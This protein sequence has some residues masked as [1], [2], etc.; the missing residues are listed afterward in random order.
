ME[1]ITM[2]TEVKITINGKNFPNFG[3]QI[4]KVCDTDNPIARGTREQ[5][6]KFN[7]DEVDAFIAGLRDVLGN[8]EIVVHVNNVPAYALSGA[9]LA[10]RM[11][12]ATHAERY[13]VKALQPKTSTKKERVED[14]TVPS[15]D[16][17]A[18]F[19]A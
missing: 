12:L 15:V 7:Q 3:K 2:A 19:I 5:L 8:A 18:D 17:L 13:E 10:N 11:E 9:Q 6:G 4:H 1:I 16:M 14:M